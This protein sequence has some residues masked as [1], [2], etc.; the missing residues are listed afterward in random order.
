MGVGV[1]VGI[2]VGVGV[3]AGAAV[4]VS[5]SELVLAVS[6]SDLVSSVACSEL[7]SLT[8]ASHEESAHPPVVLE[9]DACGGAG[10]TPLWEQDH[11]EM[12]R[13]KPRGMNRRM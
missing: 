11:V 9:K 3:G 10:P 2:G 6:G 4:G 7:T 12:P 8:T 5:S 13:I 1:A